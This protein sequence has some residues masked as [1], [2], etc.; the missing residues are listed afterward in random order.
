L[1][2]IIPRKKDG[3]S[4]HLIARIQPGQKGEMELFLVRTGIDKP[5]SIQVTIEIIRL[6]PTLSKNAMLAGGKF[7]KL[8]REMEERLSRF[9]H[10]SQLDELQRRSHMG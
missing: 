5:E 9:I 10:Q 7:L 1:S 2:I 4:N 3:K 8:K 6:H